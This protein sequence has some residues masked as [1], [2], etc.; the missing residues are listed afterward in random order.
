MIPSASRI[1]EGK[2][3]HARLQPTKHAFEYEVYF[4]KLDVDEFA[5]VETEPTGAHFD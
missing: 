3:W 1:V 2:I 4:F 5:N